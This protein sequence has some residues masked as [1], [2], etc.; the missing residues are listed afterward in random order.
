MQ[1]DRNLPKISITNLVPVVLLM[2]GSLS[3]SPWRDGKSLTLRVWMLLAKWAR[4]WA[5]R[6]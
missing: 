2:V 1:E 6:D 3:T 5:R 4:T